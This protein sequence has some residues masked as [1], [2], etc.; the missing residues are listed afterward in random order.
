[1]A[2]RGSQHL[3]QSGSRRITNLDPW[4]HEGANLRDAK[5]ETMLR[6]LDPWLHE[7]ANN[8]NLRTTCY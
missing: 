6:D 8:F 2:P 1:M 4:L 5:N 3:T 7:G